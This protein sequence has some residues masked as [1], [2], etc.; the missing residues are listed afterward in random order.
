MYVSTRSELHELVEQMR[1]SEVLAVDTEFHSERTY[2]PKL[3]LIQLGSDEVCAIVDPLQVDDLTPLRELFEDRGMVKVFHS[4]NQDIDILNRAIG[5][6]PSPVFDTQV[7]AGLLGHSQQ[8]G[9][10]ALVKAFCEVS[11]PKADSL[12]DWT[13]R[14]LTDAQ[15]EYALDD[16]RYLPNIYHIMRKRLVDSGRLDWLADDFAQLAD[17]ESYRSRPEEAWR[18][19]K[20]VSSL[21][22][23]QL[24]VAQAVAAWRERAAQHRDIP[25]K[26]ML[27]DEHVVE[28]AR[29]AP[30]SKAALFEVRGVSDHIGDRQAAEIVGEIVAALERDPDTWPKVQHR[31][32]A[33]SESAGVVDC[34]L[35]LLH[36]RARENG[37][38][39][40]IIATKDDLVRLA[41]GEGDGLALMSGWRRKL[42]GDELLDLLDGKVGMYVQDG[43]LKVTKSPQT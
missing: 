19:V 7:A 25:R 41:R 27:A 9:Y 32:H 30:R 40:Q 11:L 18:K 2:Y 16:V 28:I 31:A 8:T 6:V 22:R 43:T 24:A 14:P 20:R 15:V 21:T 36:L 29:R 3:C 38:A 1:G 33:Q 26:W 42:V 17:P 34:M 23:K 35:A 5:A 12:T 39:S 13:R 4:G 10:G 37:V